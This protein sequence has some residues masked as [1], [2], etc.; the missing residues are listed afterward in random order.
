[1]AVRT[2]EQLKSYFETGD[3]PTE[4][5]FSDL[6]DTMVTEQELEEALVNFSDLV[7][8]TYQSLLDLREDSLLVPGKFYRITDYI[9][10]TTQ[11]GTQSA[12]HQF[13]LIVLALS[14]SELSEKAFAHPHVEGDDNPISMT[15]YRGTDTMTVNYGG[16]K[17]VNG[18]VMYMWL[19]GID[20]A[21]TYNKVPERGSKLYQVSNVNG[22]LIEIPWLTGDVQ[23]SSTEE[24]F[25]NSKLSAWQIWYCLDND[26]ERFTWADTE[27]GKGVIY[28]MVDEFG[29]DCSYDFKNIQFRN[30][31]DETDAK[32]Y[33]TFSYTGNGGIVDQSLSKICGNNKIGVRRIDNKFVL[34]NIIICATDETYNTYS[35][36]FGDGCHSIVMGGGYYNTFGAGCDSISIGYAPR[37][38]VFGD[39]CLNISMLDDCFNNNIGSNCSNLAFGLHCYSNTFEDG[40]VGVKFVS[41]TGNPRHYI[42]FNKIGVGCRYVHIIN[43]QA[44]NSSNRLQYCNMAVGTRG[45][46]D[47][48]L[49]ITGITRN[50]Q[51]ETTIAVDSS[52]N[53]K[54]FCLADIIA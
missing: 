10:T 5:N 49:Q 21:Y 1:M 27:N 11:S 30:P 54:Q 36:I 15:L 47:N 25:R 41:A 3:V 22:V 31:F 32:W 46:E 14:T 17:E 28:R 35:N 52:G 4:E 39:N 29:N 38:N 40:C 51:Y 26:I 20:E 48:P 7:P 18:T 24:Y 13:D 37:A 23:F 42:A 19:A 8:I 2:K 33:Y 16:P 53:I 12:G 6:I 43:T 50:R 9:T 34:N 45:T 44:A